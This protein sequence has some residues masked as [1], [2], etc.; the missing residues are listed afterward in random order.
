MIFSSKDFYSWIALERALPEIRAEREADWAAGV[1]REFMQAA[2]VRPSVKSEKTPSQ[3]SDL[4]INEIVSNEGTGALG[5][6]K[7]GR[8]FVSVTNL[9]ASDTAEES[10]EILST[11]APARGSDLDYIPLHVTVPPQESLLLPLEEP[12]CFA[13]PENAPCGDSVTTAQR[14]IP[15]RAAGGKDS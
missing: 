10:F 15:G 14:R 4:L 12:V 6:R 7:S 2:G 1:L 5:A 9:S 3:P 11:A 8:G 13:D